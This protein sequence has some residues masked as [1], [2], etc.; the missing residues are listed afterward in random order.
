MTFDDWVRAAVEALLLD[1]AVRV[2]N[3]VGARR[4]VSAHHLALAVPGLCHTHAPDAVV[5]DDCA[6]CRR[7][8]NRFAGADRAA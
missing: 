7:R 8:G 2:L 6:W 1:H 4:R 5:H 3:A